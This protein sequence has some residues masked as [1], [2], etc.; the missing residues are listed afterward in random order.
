MSY[1]KNMQY[2]D[3][4]KEFDQFID[5]GRTDSDGQINIT[6]GND[7][8]PV[9]KYP[10]DETMKSSYVFVQEKED[11]YQSRM[12]ISNNTLYFVLS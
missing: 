9:C 6:S 3:N 2:S 4:K 12:I 7:S 11:I 8:T 5:G 1:G 10:A